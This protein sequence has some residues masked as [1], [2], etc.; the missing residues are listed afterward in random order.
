MFSFRDRQHRWD[1]RNQRS[2]LWSNYI[3]WV[4][5][6]ESIRVFPLSNWTELDIWQY[7]HLENIPLVPLYF[8]APRPV[9]RREQDWIVIDDDRM[10]LLPGE[11]PE[12]RTVRFRTMGC[13]P[14]TGAVDSTA[15]TRPE[16]L[17]EML[18]TRVSERQG[19]AVDRDEAG[20]MEKK[21]REAYF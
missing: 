14:V 18:T 6:G 5:R 4:H 2:E 10:R 13:Y 12:L 21:K 8:A 16:I 1:P 7:I 9:V 19:R 3:T 11:Q 17:R 15:A 20:A